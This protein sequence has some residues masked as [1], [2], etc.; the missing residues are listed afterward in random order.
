MRFSFAD[1]RCRTEE[2][3]VVN[4][5]R[6]TIEDLLRTNAEQSRKYESLKAVIDSN[7]S[8]DAARSSDNGYEPATPDLNATMIPIEIPAMKR[9]DAESEAP[10]A[11]PETALL[12]NYC[13][14]IRRLIGEVEDEGYR[15]GRDMRCRIRDSVIQ[16]HKRETQLLRAIYGHTELKGK[17]SE[18]SWRLAEI[19]GEEAKDVEWLPSSSGPMFGRS[20]E[21]GRPH[22][23]ANTSQSSQ[24][25]GNQKRLGDFKQSS[26]N[27]N[28]TT[29]ARARASTFYPPLSLLLNSRE[30]PWTPQNFVSQVPKVEEPRALGDKGWVP[31]WVSGASRPRLR[32]ILPSNPLK[33]HTQDLHMPALPSLR[34]GTSMLVTE[35]S[36]DVESVASS[37]DLAALTDSTSTET[38]VSADS[39]VDELALDSRPLS[40]IDSDKPEPLVALNDP[41]YTRPVEKDPQRPGMT[42]LD[43]SL[44]ELAVV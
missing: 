26:D 33:S 39:D 37:Q 23:D 4:D 29:M 25:N 11:D 9:S 2:S 12:D 5:Q 35:K 30:D 18:S 20:E 7:K 22:P 41:E 8:F 24:D 19:A 31:F 10:E 21:S 27:V 6:I 28:I 38:F 16:V 13:L 34:S 43:L 44:S 1:V 32:N 42:N 15:I 14:L 40:V 36:H 17:M 3:S